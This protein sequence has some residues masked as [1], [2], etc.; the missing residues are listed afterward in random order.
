M[1]GK[2]IE[3][4][5]IIHGA[6]SQQVFDAFTQADLLAQ[7]W[8]PHIA[9]TTYALDARTGG[10][11]EIRSQMAGIGVRGQFVALQPPSHIRLTWN[12]MNDGVSEVEEAVDIHIEPANNGTTLTLTHYL[13]PQAGDGANLR[14]GWNDVLGRLAKL[15]AS[16]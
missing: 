5:Q 8:W 11:Y 3:L 6:T 15:W 13:S 10:A 7:W 14:Q 9:D 2:T 16:P 12:W 1:S 4:T